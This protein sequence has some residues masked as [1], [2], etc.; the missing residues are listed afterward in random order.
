MV[1]VIMLRLNFYQHS[2]IVHWERVILIVWQNL[3]SWPSLS[4]DQ[5]YFIKFK[6]R[7]GINRIIGVDFWNKC[8]QTYR[9]MDKRMD[10]QKDFVS[11]W[12]TSHDTHYWNIHWC[13]ALTWFVCSFL[14]GENY[15]LPDLIEQG[16]KEWLGWNLY[17]SRHSWHKNSDKHSIKQD[18]YYLVNKLYCRM[19]LHFC[20]FFSKWL[21]Y[22][23]LEMIEYAKMWL[24]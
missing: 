4:L 2:T 23:L 10:E 9:Q 17:S 20:M 22:Q 8:L 12:L 13:T 21:S 3:T 5:S 16:R 7:N 24:G 1:N 14:S 11:L 6:E 18:G 19:L 15:Q